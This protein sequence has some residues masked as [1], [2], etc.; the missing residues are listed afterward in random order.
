MLCHI[1]PENIAASRLLKKNSLL[2]KILVNISNF[3]YSKVDKIIV[4]GRDMFE[5]VSLKLKNHSGT[6][7]KHSKLIICERSF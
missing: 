5:V 7:I 1:F 4:I 3:M 2:L 6:E